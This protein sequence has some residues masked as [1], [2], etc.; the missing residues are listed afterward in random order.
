MCP[1]SRPG[2][3]SNLILKSVRLPYLSGQAQQEAGL[4]AGN[5]WTASPASDSTI[6]HKWNKILT[7]TAR[8]P[9]GVRDLGGHQGQLSRSSCLLPS[10]HRTR[11]GI[12]LGSHREAAGGKA[13]GSS[14]VPGHWLASLSPLVCPSGSSANLE[15]KSSPKCPTS[16]KTLGDPLFIGSITSADV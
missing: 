14:L 16:T 8:Q 5:R 2:P 1:R 7:R 9:A 13:G 4:W 15:Q 12:P 11:S 6:S 10:N 3:G